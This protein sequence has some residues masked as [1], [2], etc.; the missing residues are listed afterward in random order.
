MPAPSVPGVS[1]VLALRVGEVRCCIDL[2]AVEQVV[3]LMAL[4]P[5]PGAPP[6]V[7]G[8]FNYGGE[9]VAVVD[10]AQRLRLPPQPPYT[11]DT[12]VVIGQRRRD[13]PQ[14]GQ[15]GG[16]V[17]DDVYG[18]TLFQPGDA[19]HQENFKSKGLPFKGTL[20]TRFGMALWLDI[21]A[22]L[23]VGDTI[24]RPQLDYAPS[25]DLLTG[26]LIVLD[27]VALARSAMHA[28][29]AAHTREAFAPG[30]AQ[31]KRR[32]L[33][34]DDTLTTRKL[35]THIVEAHGYEA[36]S[37]AHGREALELLRSGAT[38]DLVVTDL[39]MPEMDGAQL[40]QGIR[41]TVD[42]RYLRGATGRGDG[43]GAKAGSR[44][45]GQALGCANPL[46]GNLACDGGRESNQTPRPEGRAAH[47]QACRGCTGD[48]RRVASRRR[49]RGGS[50]NRRHRRVGRWPA[51]VGR[52]VITK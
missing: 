37:C 10:L 40:T 47:R 50:G 3:S 28:T 8:F 49:A 27:D 17:V 5:L 29:Q 21:D 33:V 24:A 19:S 16:L 42:E 22:V 30:E 26:V 31:R 36:A 15:R 39:Q 4:T 9:T 41:Q 11:L 14:A 20:Q 1:Q 43:R 6:C 18:L 25:A 7:Q 12:S 2:D 52:R 32:I 13:G 35:E 34:V 48:T 44:P 51:S 46:A 23:D 45:A 38:F